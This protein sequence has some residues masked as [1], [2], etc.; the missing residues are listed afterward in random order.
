MRWLSAVTLIAT[1][2]IGCGKDK[3]DA[4]PGATGPGSSGAAVADDTT[5]AK[6]LIASGAA[7]ID[8]R[9]QDEWD[10]GHLPQA[11]LFPVGTIDQHTDEIA[12]LAGGKD[13]PVVVYCKSGGRAGKAKQVLE[14]AGFTRV[15]N[16]GG[17]R[18]LA[19]P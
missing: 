17:Y 10:E 7:V 1:L 4:A 9:E 8:V 11:K 5:I 16:G 15:V 19:A 18:K 6:Q 14:A 3:T 2:V 13:K 12:Q